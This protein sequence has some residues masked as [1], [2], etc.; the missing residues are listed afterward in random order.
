MARGDI[1][2]ARFECNL[3]MHKIVGNLSPDEFSAWV[4]MN[5][6]AIHERRDSFNLSEYSWQQLGKCCGYSAGKTER[7]FQKLSKLGLFVVT[8]NAITICGV[9]DKNRGFTW[10]DSPVGDNVGN[11]RVYGSGS[12]SDSDITTVVVGTDGETTGPQAWVAVACDLTGHKLPTDTQW[13]ADCLTWAGVCFE[14]YGD[15]ANDVLSPVVTRLKQG[16]G[17]VYPSKVLQKAAEGEGGT[18]GLIDFDS[19]PETE[20]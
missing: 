10:K 6:Y 16:S 19:I 17:V 2:Y 15:K 5:L 8:D 1:P 13:R 14:R 18:R 7:I 12:G 20:E 3:F 9:R 11:G 4:K